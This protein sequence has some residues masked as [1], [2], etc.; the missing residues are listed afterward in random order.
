MGRDHYAAGQRT[1]SYKAVIWIVEFP[2]VSPAR[3]AGGLPRPKAILNPFGPNVLPM[4]PESVTTSV[5]N[6]HP[7]S[8][9]TPPGLTEPRALN[10][11]G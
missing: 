7:S 9:A 1:P 2:K 11:L 8:V 10:G 4:S 3:E 6:G 5:R